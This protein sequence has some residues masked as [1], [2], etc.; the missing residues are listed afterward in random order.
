MREQQGDL[1]GAIA[2]YTSLIEMEGVSQEL[3]GKALANR[4]KLGPA[5]GEDGDGEAMR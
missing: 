4:T 5:R 3:R 2:D 1:A